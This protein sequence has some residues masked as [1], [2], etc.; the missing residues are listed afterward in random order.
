MRIYGIG[1]RDALR[2]GCDKI[3]D[4]ESADSRVRAHVLAQGRVQGVGFRAFLQSQATRR[5]LSGWV[6]N[7]PDGRIETE[8]EGAPVLVEEFIQAVKRGPSLAQV[9]DIHVKWINPNTQ[10]SSD[11]IIIPGSV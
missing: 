11:F 7:L 6:R 5:G 3:V 9:Q 4:R 10:G 1:L 2:I 8:V